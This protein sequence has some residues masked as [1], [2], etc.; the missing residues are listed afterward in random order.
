MFYGEGLEFLA[1]VLDAFVRTL[2]GQ[3]IRFHLGWDVHKSPFLNGLLVLLWRVLSKT[4]SFLISFSQSFVGGH[5]VDARSWGH[6][7]A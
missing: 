4:D 2:P 6:S 3:K 5:Q 1:E 7:S